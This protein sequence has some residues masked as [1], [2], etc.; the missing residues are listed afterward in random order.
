MAKVTVI[1]EKSVPPPKKYVLELSEDEALVLVQLLYERV[2]GHIAT[3][4]LTAF[5]KVNLYGAFDRHLFFI[6]G[7]CIRTTFGN[8]EV[9]D[10]ANYI[11]QSKGD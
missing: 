2:S 7:N 8:N 6:D 11:R 5:E 3:R 1:E 9:E 4:Y 10:M